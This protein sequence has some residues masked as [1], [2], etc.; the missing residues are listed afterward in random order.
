[1]GIMVYTEKRTKT[2]SLIIDTFIKLYNDNDISKITVKN[3]C[4][5]AKINRS[6]FYS[7]YLD[8]YDLREKLELLALNNIEKN[9]DTML[10]SLQDAILEDLYIKIT[11]LLQDNNEVFMLFLRKADKEFLQSV[12]DIIRTQLLEKIPNLNESDMRLLDYCYTYHFNAVSAVL[13][14]WENDDDGLEFDE[15]LS[16]IFE[17]AN[18][19]AISV[20]RNRYLK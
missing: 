9:M 13:K 14:K 16:Y 18:S 17:I 20:L 6:T 7:Y 2:N 15:V 8:V 10:K 1:M 5:K 3:I 12:I 11:G 4:D 19:G